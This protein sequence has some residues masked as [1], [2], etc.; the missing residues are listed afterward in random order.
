[1]KEAATFS[2]LLY[3]GKLVV[4]SRQSAPF[5]DQK[6]LKQDSHFTIHQRA[7][8]TISGT[9]PSIH[10]F[11]NLGLLL[12]IIRPPPGCHV[13]LRP[14]SLPSPSPRARRQPH[15]QPSQTSRMAILRSSE[16]MGQ[17]KL[18]KP[19]YCSSLFWCC[20]KMCLVYTGTLHVNLQIQDHAG[21]IQDKTQRY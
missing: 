7:L 14:T 15:I 1:M 3:V 18:R 9:G 2:R 21:G 11:Q 16:P 5:Q 13:P 8:A 17:A 20:P 6:L 10:L 19:H 4:P 12:Q